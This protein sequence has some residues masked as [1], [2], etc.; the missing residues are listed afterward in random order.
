MEA[1]IF[2]GKE[3]VKASVLAKKFRYTADYLGQLCRGKKVDAR[4]VGRAWYINL[5]SLNQ[6]KDGRYKTVAVKN[7]ESPVSVSITK[8]QSKNYLS[9]IEVEPI[10]K[11]K[12]VSIFKSK[13]GALAEFSVKY[14]SDDYSLIPRVNQGA[15]SKNIPINPAGAE[16][17]KVHK[18]GSIITDFRAEALPEVFLRGALKVSGL[19]EA[20]ETFVE[21]VPDIQPEIKL[22]RKLDP[23]KPKPI[24]VRPI[25]KTA[26]ERKNAKTTTSEKSVEAPLKVSITILP[27]PSRP[28]V[29]EVKKEIEVSV[30]DVHPNL[31][32][33][34]HQSVE[35]VSLAKPPAQALVVSAA[36]KVP[37]AAQRVSG[38]A[39]NFKPRL[40]VKKE[41]KKSIKEQKSPGWI[42]PISILFTGCALAVVL[43]VLQE[44][45]V[46]TQESFRQYFLLDWNQL[47][48]AT[49]YLKFH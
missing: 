5:E 18:E 49:Q 9:R 41:E 44:S 1:V 39:H 17:L 7:D 10:L 34:L 28:K 3:Y 45:V 14:E 6:H 23:V 21:E 42:L 25:K 38:A 12:T 30:V 47:F 16:K 43:L 22:E 32:K 24:L 40:V 27:E 15:V 26:A 33:P 2:D 37:I 46:V 20:T 4:L 48:L 11:K 8:K 19:E 29:S 13:N 35:A 31:V 36:V